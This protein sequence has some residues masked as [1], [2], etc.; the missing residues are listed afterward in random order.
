LWR[1][2]EGDETL[3]DVQALKP[4]EILIRWVNFHLKAAGQDLRIKNLGKD[5]ADSKAMT[6]VLN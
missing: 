6:Y 4:E 5:I 1:L 3:A 2:A